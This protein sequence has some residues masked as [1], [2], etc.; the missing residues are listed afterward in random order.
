LD[1]PIGKGCRKEPKEPE[2]SIKLKV[3]PAARLLHFSCQFFR[4]FQILPKLF[5]SAKLLD[6]DTMSARLFYDKDCSLK[7]LEGKTI[8]F[9]GYGNQGR[10]Q[11]LNL[12]GDHAFSSH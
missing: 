3:Y 8:V 6:N 1:I 5:S 7:P 11:A 12:A 2:D 9:I 10:A 4:H